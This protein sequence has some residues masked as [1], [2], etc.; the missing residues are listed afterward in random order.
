MQAARLLFCQHRLLHLQLHL[1]QA[2]EDLALIQRAVEANELFRLGT[3]GTH[4]GKVVL[5]GSLIL[6]MTRI[7]FQAHPPKGMLEH[8]QSILPCGDGSLPT[9]QLSPLD[10]ELLPKL[11]DRRQ[12]RYRAWRRRRPTPIR[13]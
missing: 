13:R 8:R 7:T 11:N 9:F 3:K 6:A 1:L 12:H 4:P 2:K 5:L 10:K